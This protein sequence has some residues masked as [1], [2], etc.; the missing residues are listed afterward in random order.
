MKQRKTVYG[1]VEGLDL[2]SCV[3]FLGVPFAAPPV[4]ER[5]F[6][7]PEACLPWEGVRACTAFAPACI[8]TRKKQTRQN[9]DTGKKPRFMGNVIENT[10]EDCLYLNVWTPCADTDKKAPVMVWFHGGGFANGAT[11]EPEFDGKSLCEHG[12]VVVTAAY[13]CGA[14]GFFAH[15]ALRHNGASGNWGL[16]DQI[17][18]LRW[19]QENITAF[20]GDRDRVTVFGQSGGAMSIKFLL[21]SALARGLFHRAILQSGGGIVA[22]DPCREQAEMEALCQEAMDRMGLTV[23]DLRTMDA[24]ELSQSLNDSATDVIQGKELFPFQPCMDGAVL[25]SSPEKAVLDGAYPDDIDL[26]C[27]DVSGDAWMFSRKLRPILGDRAELMQ[28]FAMAPFLSWAENASRLGKKPLYTYYFE[29][30]VP[31]FGGAPHSADLAYV[32]GT[33]SDPSYTELDREYSQLMQ[34]YWTNFA[35]TGDP[36]GEG[37]PLW[38]KCTHEARLSMHISD[39]AFRSEQLSSPS[40]DKVIAYVLRHPGMAD[41]TDGLV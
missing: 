3:A 19:V 36:N 38:P 29:R 8:Q 39:V 37:L 40:L 7:P 24:Q 25:R 33:Q 35:K 28:C 26:I 32:F 27:G 4:G 2:G 11:S 18:A 14:L 13:R 9:S 30:T 6:A 21:T 20:G 34:A 31:R 10:S 12:V 16:L 23:E 1:L 22:A 5:R 41:T 15:P 17:A